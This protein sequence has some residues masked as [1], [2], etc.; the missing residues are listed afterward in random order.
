MSVSS[1]SLALGQFTDNKQKLMDDYGINE[2]EA[3]IL[4][5]YMP[6]VAEPSYAFGDGISG[7]GENKRQ[8]YVQA[9]KDK[10]YAELMASSA[11]EYNARREDSYYQRLAVDLKKAGISPYILSPSGSSLS[12]YQMPNSSN[13]KQVNSSD[14]ID[15][16]KGIASIITTALMAYMLLA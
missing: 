4:Q 12:S 9:L 14:S 8:A 11:N 10:Y 15:I 1:G 16:V 7:K 5:H 13:A 3:T 2:Q 6:Y